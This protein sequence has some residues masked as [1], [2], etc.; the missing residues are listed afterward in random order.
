M[1]LGTIIGSDRANV[2]GVPRIC[3][4][5]GGLGSCSPLFAHH[6]HCR[7][8]FR[9]HGEAGWRPC[10]GPPLSPRPIWAALGARSGCYNYPNCPNCQNYQHYEYITSDQLPATSITVPALPYQQYQEYGR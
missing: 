10:Q 5:D 4:V 6:R 7:R 9:H 3:L 8:P 1:W 2:P